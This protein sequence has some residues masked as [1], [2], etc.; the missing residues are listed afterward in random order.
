MFHGKHLK[1]NHILFIIALRYCAIVI[2][3]IKNNYNLLKTKYDTFIPL[4]QP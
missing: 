3:R 4:S 2:R 1:F